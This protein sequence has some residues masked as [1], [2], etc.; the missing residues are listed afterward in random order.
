MDEEKSKIDPKAKAITILFLLLICGV[1]IGI[2]ISLISLNI[3]GKR[4]GEGDIIKALW[5][6]FAN[7]FTLETIMI[8][9]NMSLLLGLLISYVRSYR[10]TCSVF[11]LGLVLFLAVL[12]V[13]SLLSLPILDLIITVGSVDPRLGFSSVLI[14]YQSAIFSFLA[15]LFET[16]ALIILYY[17]SME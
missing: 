12:F 15:N 5:R 4:I 16:I 8:C 6:P 2:F 11:L 9:M 3:L 13:Q 10:R 14:S 7:N 1:I 17:L